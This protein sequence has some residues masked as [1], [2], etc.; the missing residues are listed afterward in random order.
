[1]AHGTHNKNHKEEKK[2]NLDAAALQPV[3]DKSLNTAQPDLSK[4]KPFA[5]IS[6]GFEEI[7]K[8]FKRQKEKDM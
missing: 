6:K 3:K 1:M 2:D 4:T 8:I 5:Q 7:E